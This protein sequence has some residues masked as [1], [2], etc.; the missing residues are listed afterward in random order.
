MSRRALAVCAAVLVAGGIVFVVVGRGGSAQP[1]RTAAPAVKPAPGTTVVTTPSLAAA[2]T[3]KREAEAPAVGDGFRTDDSS[4]QA[5][6]AA[7]PEPHIAPALAARVPALAGSKTPAPTG[8]AVVK[9]RL[10][11][12]GARAE[13][14]QALA[15]L[16]DDPKNVDAIRVVV[17]GSCAIGDAPTAHKYQAQLPTGDRAQMEAEC[18]K[19]GVNL[20]DHETWKAGTVPDRSAPPKQRPH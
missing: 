6:E 16:A 2:A 19:S 20:A 18:R 1:S 13:R 4:E 7:L 14:D 17:S 3:A 5:S 12:G 8:T 11:G 10:A 9:P 15:M